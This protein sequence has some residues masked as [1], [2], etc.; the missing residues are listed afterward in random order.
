MAKLP[1][2]RPLLPEWMPPALVIWFEDLERGVG[3]VA[4]VHLD[5]AQNLADLVDAGAARENIGLEIGVDVQAYSATLD[6][7]TASFTTALETKLN[8]IEASADVTDATNVTAAGALM[9]S[10]LTNLALVKGLDAGAAVAD[11]SG[12]STIDAEARTAINSLLAELRTN[13]IIAT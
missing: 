8:G 12:G 13:G 11:A 7:T 10:E 3:D 6:G 4:I 5:S 2:I 1:P 9:D